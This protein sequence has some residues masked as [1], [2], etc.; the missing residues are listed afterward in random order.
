MDIPV[1]VQQVLQQLEGAGYQAWCVG[2]CV[3]DLLLGRTPQDW[4]VTTN[5]RPEQTMAVFG[6]CA[7]PTGLQHGTIT[8]V[9]GEWRI[10]VTTYRTE[11]GYAD[12]RRP[13]GVHF[14]DDIKHDLARRD[15]TI[16]AMALN[17]AGDLEDPF[18]GQLDLAE[19]MLRCVGRSDV[20]FEEDALRILRGLRFAS[21]LDF[22]IA[23]DTAQSI[24]AHKQLLSYIAVERIWVELGNLFCGKNPMPILREYMDVF[25]VFWPELL[26]MEGFSQQNPHHCYDL[27]EHTIHAVDAV[28]NSLILRTSAVLHDIGKVKTFT[29]DS[30]GI[31]HFCGH[32]EAGV[33]I[34][35]AM[36]HR[37]KVDTIT[38]EAVVMLV[39]WHDHPIVPTEKAVKRALGKLGV[40]AFIDLLKIKRADNL[41]QHPA[42]QGRQ[43]EITVL[44]GILAQVL[45]EKQCFSLP[46][47]AVDGHDLIRL[48]YQGIAIGQELK[49]L[50]DLVIDGQAS[51]EKAVLLQLA[52][53][54]K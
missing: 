1:Q 43:Q 16:N 17:L 42:F 46:Q 50:L 52:Y 36:L 39:K 8:V 19:K 21:Q 53:E 29:V 30:D 37:L 34:A 4:D 7:I 27:W 33:P 47:L 5:A 51:N 22:V 54:N 44:E 15:F 9:M 20:R 3:R 38:R 13:D 12:H 49:R 45:A 24:H 31:G 23:P 26:P 28:E 48:E 10:E 2:G 14:V 41:A 11:G 6:H 25:G 32:Q 40:D 18:D 35:D